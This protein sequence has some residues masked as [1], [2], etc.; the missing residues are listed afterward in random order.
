MKNKGIQ[1]F[2]RLF[3]ILFSFF[4]MGFVDVVNISTSYVKADFALNDKTANLLPMMVFLWFA[5]CSLPVGI[6]MNHI[7]R[8]KTVIISLVLTV[9]AMLLPLTS[10]SFIIVLLA[11]ALLGI[12]N[13]ILQVSLN[14]LL[15][16]VIN[17]ERMT[18]MLTLGQFIKAISSTL[19]PI[20]IGLAVSLTGN[21]KIVFPVYAAI[22]ILPLIWLWLTPVEE[23]DSVKVTKGSGL[24]L[25]FGDGYLMLLFSVI[26]LIV[27]FEIGLMTSTP[28]FLAEHFSLSLDKGGLGCSL[29]YVARTTGTFIGAIILA[30]ISSGRF[31][32]YSIGGAI[33]AL[34][35]FMYTG[36]LYIAFGALFLLGLLCANVFAIILSKALQYKP[37]CANEIS[38]VII[39]GVAGGALFP[40]VMGIISDM[41]NQFVSLFVLLVSLA[42]IFLVSLKLKK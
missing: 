26:V 32:T 20:I 14:P 41:S 18:S 2:L 27:G 25:V 22:T 7:G 19:G 33:V 1:Q 8:R 36:N 3:P 17:K 30:R 6:L 34:L 12:S 23:H 38:A 39:M 5:V 16:D 42:Y 31:L 35:L 9:I 37:D 11:F 21:W 29:Y 24:K 10:Y 28:K 4:V 40:P 13:T 15:T